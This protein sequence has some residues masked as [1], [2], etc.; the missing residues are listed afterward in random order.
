MKNA[1]AGK[2]EQ[3]KQQSYADGVWDGMQMGLDL[4][5]IALNHRYQFGVIRLRRLEDKVQELINEIIDTRDPDVTKAHIRTA[6]RQIW[7]D[8]IDVDRSGA[9][10]DKG[11]RKTVH[12]ADCKH[13]MF[14]D[15]YGECAKGYKP[16]IVRPEDSCGRGE[17]K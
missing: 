14:S 3:V 10:A 7:G 4:C 1:F 15:C 13:L 17:A 11:V 5:A 9:D 8:R 6:L 16:G 12:C 2:L